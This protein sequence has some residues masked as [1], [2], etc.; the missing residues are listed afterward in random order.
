MGG[1]NDNRGT[2]SGNDDGETAGNDDGETAG[3]EDGVGVTVLVVGGGRGE[4]KVSDSVRD[5]RVRSTALVA[6]AV[7]PT[8]ARH[9]LSMNSST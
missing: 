3:N 5:D 6:V 4:G 1:L 8:G 9:E 2:G 7:P